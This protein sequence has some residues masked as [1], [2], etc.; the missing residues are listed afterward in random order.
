[1]LHTAGATEEKDIVT[2]SDKTF[3]V[4]RPVEM[5][6]K[7]EWEWDKMRS[8]PITE[9][10]HEKSYF[11]I[12][13]AVTSWHLCEWLAGTMTEHQF[14]KLSSA[15]GTSI[16]GTSNLRDWAT[17]ECDALNICDQLANGAKH[18]VIKPREIP[19]TAN[20]KEFLFG[21]GILTHYLMVEG[22]RSMISIDFL[23]GLTLAFWRDVFVAAGI[24]TT[25]QVAYPM[26]ERTW[27][28]K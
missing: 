27:A 26:V 21:D 4:K 1:M 19:F 14:E 6:A 8:F 22:P 2:M 20:E 9:R 24:A 13:A 11:A 18:L 3:G 23:I 12:N 15:A 28:A 25:E 7:L 17:R 16:R 10:C 5:L